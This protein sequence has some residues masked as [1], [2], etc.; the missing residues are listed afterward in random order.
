MF[1]EKRSTYE[2]NSP[3]RL[4]VQVYIHVINL[5]RRKRYTFLETVAAKIRNF[6]KKLYPLFMIILQNLKIARGKNWTNLRQN[7]SQNQL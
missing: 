3:L 6:F 2:Q 5:T 1:S 4:E 7:L